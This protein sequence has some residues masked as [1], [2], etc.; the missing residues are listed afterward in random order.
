MI[1]YV[2][3]VVCDQN[4]CIVAFPIGSKFWFLWQFDSYLEHKMYRKI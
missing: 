1:E 2:Q 4:V 3:V